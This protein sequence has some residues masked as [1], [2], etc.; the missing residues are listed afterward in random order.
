MVHDIC[1]FLSLLRQDKCF[2]GAILWVEDLYF[3]QKQNIDVK[4]ATRHFTRHYLMDSG[5]LVDYCDVSISCLDFHS[6]GTHS[7]QKTHW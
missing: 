4:N 6:D 1:I 7:L 3:S 2:T 5:L